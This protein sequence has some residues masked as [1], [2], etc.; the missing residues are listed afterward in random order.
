MNLL[1][2]TNTFTPHVG[3]VA[4]SIEQ[5][6]A[7]YRRRGHRVL[8]VAPTFDGA[9]DEPGVVRIPA[10]EHF[11]S[12]SFSLPLPI[13][14]YIDRTIEAFQPNLIHSHHPFLLGNT[15]L[16]IAAFYDLPLVFTHHTLYEKYTHYVLGNAELLKFFVTDLAAGY[17]NLCDA[18]VA[19]SETVR[20]SLREHG[21]ERRIEVIP[22]GVVIDRFARGDGSDCR[23]EHG[24]P[25][26]AFV[27]GHVGRL[28]AEKNLRFLARS[29]AHF[30][31]EHEDVWCL[32]AG[33]G[34]CEEEIRQ[35]FRQQGVADRLV[36]LGVQ[37]VEH[38]SDI[39]HAMDLFA[40]ASQ[41]ETQGMVLTEALAAGVPVV[42]VE[43][44]GVRETIRNGSNG[45][46]LP[47]PA[48]GMFV[49]ALTK[50]YTMPA[51]QLGRYQ[52]AARQTAQEFS[53]ANTAGRMLALYQSLI[54]DPTRQHHRDVWSSAGRRI[55]QEWKLWQ[56]MLD[57]AGEA[58]LHADYAE[59]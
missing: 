24:I 41:S 18:V 40:F 51:Q 32:I 44:P 28:A 1:M 7:E 11:N 48:I 6:A 27:V 19:P 2:I 20:D 50:F 36:L 49:S 12:S 38:L 47:R 45:L 59:L 53:M 17:C 16:R 55:A 3:G 54:E 10:V 58:V 9:V 5:F 30:A 57:S 39:Y 14:G 37:P 33:A 34:P 15:A 42:A 22:T 23:R 8:V 21:V 46:L 29:V 52:T 4:R 43:G 35:E 13:P 31:A 26:G 56:N 25:A